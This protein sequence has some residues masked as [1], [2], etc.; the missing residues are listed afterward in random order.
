[1]VLVAA[2]AGMAGAAEQSGIGLQWG[3][4]PALMF[5]PF[6]QMKMAD[7]FAVSWKVSD[8]VSIAVFRQEGWIGGTH[9]YTNDITIPGQTFKQRL[10]IDAIYNING[11]AIATK[12][13]A[14]TFLTLGMELGVVD[15]TEVDED[16]TDSRGVVGDVGDFGNSRDALDGQGALEGITAKLTLLKAETKTINT[17]IG[18]QAALRFVQLPTLYVFG[19]QETTVDP[20]NNPVL[21]GI[22]PIHSM[23]SLDV[24]V[25]A[26][27]IF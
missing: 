13:P 4:G 26:S 5:G 23:N 15:V 19:R 14:I 27:L 3:I 22:D 16:Y 21:K 8:D 7:S 18:I 24:R 1:V 20:A 6:D 9:E 10:T 12:I 2:G 11:I 17:D 25:V